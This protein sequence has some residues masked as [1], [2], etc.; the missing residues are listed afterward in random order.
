MVVQIIIYYVIDLHMRNYF[1]VIEKN[2]R[3]AY[4]QYTLNKH[5]KRINK[6]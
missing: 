2:Q 4:V 5:G 1:V 6:I 3:R